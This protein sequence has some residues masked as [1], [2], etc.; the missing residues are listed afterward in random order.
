MVMQPDL[1]ASENRVEAPALGLWQ[2][3]QEDWIAHGRDWTK[4]GFRAVAVQRFGA[5]RMQVEPKLLRA[6]LSILYRSL[7]RKVRNTYGIDLPYTVKLG[8]RVVI[9]HQGAIIIHGY[10]TIGDDCIIRQGV[11]LGNRYLDKPLESPQLGDRVNVGAGAK[12]LG[13]VNL[14]DDVNIGANA[15]VLSD[16]PAGQTAVGIPAKMIATKKLQDK[17]T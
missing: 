15:V 17:N 3:I 2:Q 6:P 5:W 12:I 7:Y 4:P 13:K 9:E 14:G 16:I 8:R 11:T 10:C 1:I